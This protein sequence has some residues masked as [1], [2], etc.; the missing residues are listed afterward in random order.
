MLGL[1]EVGK[2]VVQEV[3]DYAIYL[4]DPDGRILSWNQGGEAI[5]G[6]G[7][8]EIRGQSFA[9]FYTPEDRA[10]GKPQQEMRIASREGRHEDESW[11]VRKDGSRFW[12]NEVITAIHDQTGQPYGYVKIIRDLSGRKRM[13][14]ELRKSEERYRRVV[15]GVTDYAIFTLDPQRRVTSWNQAAQRIIGYSEQ[16]ISG[17]SAD[18]IFTPEDRARGCRNGR[19]KRR[20]AKAAPRTSGGIFARMAFVSGGAAS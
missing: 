6:Y 16:E 10:A 9:I 15:E 7:P 19:W 8:E 18:V 14:D 20:P 11:R 2:W 17:Q 4:L 12:G 5:L 1:S 13:E 3:K